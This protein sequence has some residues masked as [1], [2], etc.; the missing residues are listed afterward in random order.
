MK[1]CARGRYA[2]MALVELA[3]YT[4]A[5]GKN[6]PVRLGHIADRHEISRSHLEL[7][8]G[9]LRKHGLV[10]GARGPGG[11]Y[12]LARATDQIFIS[13]I[14]RAV[15]DP[16][17]VSSRNPK[18]G[19]GCKSQDDGHVTLDF[20]H[21]LSIQVYQFLDT[22]TLEDVRSRN[23]LKSNAANEK[24]PVRGTITSS[25]G[26]YSANSSPLPPNSSGTSANLGKPSLRHQ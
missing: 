19:T 1:L 20:W 11:G 17:R 3:N 12:R 25:L 21:E 26:S 13:D 10:I 9:Q 6:K 7:L 15:E 22:V 4:V 16:E 23:F 24:P 5:T 18:N 14:V 8:F 2:V